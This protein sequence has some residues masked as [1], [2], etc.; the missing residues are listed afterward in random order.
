MISERKFTYAAAI[1][2]ISLLLFAE[3]CSNTF[4]VTPTTSLMD[5]LKNRGAVP[6]SSQNPYLA[7]NM[8]VSKEI[9]RSPE[10]KGFVRHQGAPKAIEVVKQLLKPTILRLYYPASRQY[11]QM[12]Q[13]GETWIISGPFEIP[14]SG[15]KL[16]DRIIEKT[17]SPPAL[18]ADLSKS[19]S[20]QRASNAERP[21]K[22]RSHFPPVTPS[23]LQVARLAKKPLTQVGKPSAEERKIALIKSLQTKSVETAEQTPK[24]DIVHYVTYNGETLIMISRWYTHDWR[25]VGK[26]ARIN[27]LKHPNLLEI[28][29]M[30]II[31]SYLVKS[32]V[33]LTKEA[34]DKLKTVH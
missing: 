2:F 18:L 34:V 29:D 21:E 30:I 14:D 22:L 28:G 31:P 25:N 26:L 12:E 24:G 3:G 23:T 17:P 5:A 13:R 8:L 20:R 1:W 15:M 6:L 16:L 19:K 10:F 9:E 27:K 33:R 7:A 11:F 4:T 32:T